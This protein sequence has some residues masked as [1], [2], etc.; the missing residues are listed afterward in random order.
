[1]PGSGC[2]TSSWPRFSLHQFLFIIWFFSLFSLEQFYLW[3]FHGKSSQILSGSNTQYLSCSVLW[4]SLWRHTGGT[5]EVKHRWRVSKWPKCHQW[6]LAIFLVCGQ[7]LCSAGILFCRCPVCLVTEHTA[8][9]SH[10]S[11]DC[12][13]TKSSVWTPPR[14]Q[15]TAGIRC[16]DAPSKYV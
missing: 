4:G 5:L 3:A 7:Q 12:V 9:F 2:S 15:R 11:L 14:K 8:L 10:F 16:S 13:V 1:M 6:E